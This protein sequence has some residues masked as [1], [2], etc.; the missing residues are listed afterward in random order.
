MQYLRRIERTLA[1]GATAD[2]R[3]ANSRGDL[4]VIGEDRADVTLVAQIAV[5]ARDEASG[6]ERLDAVEIPV[7]AE[8]E[9]LVVGPPAYPESDEH[10][11]RF[12]RGF[13]DDG[14][15]FPFGGLRFGG[16]GIIAAV[17]RIVI[18]SDVRVDME[19]RVP[20]RC[21]VNA[22]LRAGTLRVSGVHAG[23]TARSRSGRCEIADIGGDVTLETHSGH[24][25]VHAIRGGVKVESRSGRIDI[26]EVDGDL[27]VDVRSGR[28]DGRGVG[29]RA[30][31]RG[32]SGMVRLENARGPVEISAESGAVEVRG[33]VVAPITIDV[34][35]GSA[36]IAVPADARFY[37]DAESRL[38]SVRSDLP[39]GE[40]ERP[41]AD[42]L[43]VRVRTEMGSI[44]IVPL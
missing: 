28:F 10:A 13:H 27:D 42:A 38:G 30:R 5:E 21:A 11:H 4:V 35:A 1:A 7:A 18:D 12:A 32:Q 19:L 40:D 25:T 44:R 22:D 3:V 37:L 33:P 2:L 9:H 14:E 34:R 6:R 26:S 17:R 8:G 20:R 39:V 24:A 16:T 41:P 31:V 15:S 23:V 29:G 36:R 43:T